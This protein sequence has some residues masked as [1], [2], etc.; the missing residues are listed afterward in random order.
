MK[1]LI[2]FSALL[3]FFVV[4]LNLPTAT[5]ELDKYDS[6]CSANELVGRCAD[7][8]TDCPYAEQIP[9]DSPKCQPA[10]QNPPETIENVPTEQPTTITEPM[11]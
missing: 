2:L 11:K 7:K 10:P 6:Q 9:L 8:P 3:L 4:D 5:A 1:R